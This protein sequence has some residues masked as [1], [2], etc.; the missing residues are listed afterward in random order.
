MKDLPADAFGAKILQTDMAPGCNQDQASVL[1][2]TA[3]LNKTS[4]NQGLGIKGWERKADGGP[5]IDQHL[6]VMVT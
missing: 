4:W 1:P 6:P 3:L 2:G 5:W